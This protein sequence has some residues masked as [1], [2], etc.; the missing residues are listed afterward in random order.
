VSSI[1]PQVIEDRLETATQV[2]TEQRTRTVEEIAA[3]EQFAE[4]L[5]SM[6][7]QESPGTQRSAVHGPGGRSID[8][9]HEVRTAYE[10]TF[11]DVSH[12]EQEFGESYARDI[13]EE[14]GP[15]IAALL[16]DGTSFGPQHRET[17][18]TAV[19][20]SR[21]QRERFVELLDEEHDSLVAATETL[22]A[23]ATELGDIDQTVFPN[24]SAD[25]LDAH[26][27]RLGVLEEKC[28]RLLDDRQSTLVRQRHSTRFPIDH[29]DV[30]QYLYGNLDSDYPVV[31]TVAEL[32]DCIERLRGELAAMLGG[33]A[34]I[35][36]SYP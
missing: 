5:Q 16:I 18:L 11:M 1:D 31:S 32:L 33:S 35:R 6:K 7:L 20:V 21:K 4:R 14:F 24:H 25:V 12:Y 27:T 8:R 9:L 3:L 17:V 10:S 13:C 34:S 19:S 26:H 15:D 29:P 23:L 30:P 22:L 36:Q 2:T 28:T